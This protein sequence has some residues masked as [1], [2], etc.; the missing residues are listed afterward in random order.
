MFAFCLSAFTKPPTDGFP[1][2]HLQP[3]ADPFERHRRFP[4]QPPRQGDLH[5]A[6]LAL[7]L[8]KRPLPGG[9]RGSSNDK[10]RPDIADEPFAPCS[11]A[12][13]FRPPCQPTMRQAKTS[14]SSCLPCHPVRRSSV[15]RSDGGFICPSFSGCGWPRWVLRH[16]ARSAGLRIILFSLAPLF[17]SA[18]TSISAYLCAPCAL[19]W[20]FRTRH[21]APS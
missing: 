15:P 11:K 6:A 3:V 7:Q 13:P 20:R 5:R 16:S 8:Q 19:S 17:G 21:S 14:S 18:K 2:P 12:P 1:G 4:S 10:S 9:R